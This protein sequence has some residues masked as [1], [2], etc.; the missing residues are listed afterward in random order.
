MASYKGWITGRLGYNW[1]NDR[2]G[3]LINDLWEREGFSCGEGLQVMVNDEWV[4]TRF[5]MSDQWYLVDTPYRGTDIE[6]VS[7]R[8]YGWIYED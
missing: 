1:E 6:Y 4:D 2:Y 5:E 7:A 3:L 8:V